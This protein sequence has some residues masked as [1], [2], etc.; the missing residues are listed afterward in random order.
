MVL[1]HIFEWPNFSK[2][3]EVFEEFVQQL[4]N[5][6]GYRLEDVTLREGVSLN[7][8]SARYTKT[9]RAGSRAM[10]C[11]HHGVGKRF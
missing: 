8:P 7:D 5:A 1:A 10:S 2:G 4:N 11:W 3:P 6:R 9:A